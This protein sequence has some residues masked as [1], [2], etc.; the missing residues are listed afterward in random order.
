MDELTAFLLDLDTFR[1][2]LAAG[3]VQVREVFALGARWLHEANS[4]TFRTWDDLAFLCENWDGTIVLKGVQSVRGA[5]AAIDAAWT[6]LLHHPGAS[7]HGLFPISIH[8]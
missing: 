6:A 2:R 3:D 5:H 7:T 4:G 8:A 1:T